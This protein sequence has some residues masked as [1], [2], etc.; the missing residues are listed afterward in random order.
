M[1]STTFTEAHFDMSN[2]SYFN[3]HYDVSMVKQYKIDH[4]QH[5]SAAELGESM[6]SDMK[7][8]HFDSDAPGSSMVPEGMEP[9]DEVLREDEVD[10]EMFIFPDRAKKDDVDPEDEP[11]KLRSTAEL[12]E[13]II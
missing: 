10:E 8:N 1:N 7:D 6:M 12:L 4:A 11:N 5:K 13:P 2:S 9:Q 3:K